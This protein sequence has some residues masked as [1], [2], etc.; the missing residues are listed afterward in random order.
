[1]YL[2]VL[3]VN[4][5]FWFV[6]DSSLSCGDGSVPRAVGV[7]LGLGL[8]ALV[9]TKAWIMMM[10]PMFMLK[11]MAVMV[12]MMEMVVLMMTAMLVLCILFGFAHNTCHSWL[13]ELLG[14]W[15]SNEGCR[16]I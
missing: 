2:C 14:G 5:V 7:V 9:V 1:M 3:I 6:C 10:M 4:H 16:F 13:N 12:V 8:V 15:F 11:M